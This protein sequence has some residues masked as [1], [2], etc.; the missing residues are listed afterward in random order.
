[1]RPEGLGCIMYNQDL[2]I[3]VTHQYCKNEFNFHGSQS[4]IS[5]LQNNA[6]N[7][8]LSFHIFTSLISIED[9]LSSILTL[10]MK[11]SFSP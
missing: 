3:F 2:S 4:E 6:C 7:K 11:Y 5:N 9:K 1:M 8:A 10:I